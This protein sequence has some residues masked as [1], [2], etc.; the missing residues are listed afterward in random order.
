MNYSKLLFRFFHHQVSD[1]GTEVKVF[2]ST[3]LQQKEI[4]RFVIL[5]EEI[6]LTVLD[7]SIWKGK[8]NVNQS[9]KHFVSYQ[10]SDATNNINHSNID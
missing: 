5:V 4:C 8:K 9:Q 3:T 2:R 7:K 10:D 6:K 1:V